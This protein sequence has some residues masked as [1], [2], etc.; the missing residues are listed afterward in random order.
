MGGCRGSRN[1]CTWSVPEGRAC[2]APH[3]S[4]RSAGTRS[5]PATAPS[6]STR[7]CCGRSGSRWW[8]EP[9]PRGWP[10]TSSWS[11]ARPP[12]PTPTRPWPRPSSAACPCSSTGS[13]WD[14]SPRGGA[15]WRWPGRTARPPG[16][17]CSG[18]R[19]AGSRR[20]STRDRACSWAASRARSGPTPARGTPAAGSRPRPASTTAPSTSS[21][22]RERR[23]A[24]S[25]PTT[26]TTTATS[27]RSRTRSRASPTACTR[28]A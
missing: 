24:T 12:C 20:K 7:P 6:R 1:G 17:G 23:S 22:R 19:C 4:C 5:A 11:C 27:R 28:R 21:R 14:G 3:A 15:P 8:S 25:R 2:R 16:A 13:C 9:R 18:T 26:S 10:R